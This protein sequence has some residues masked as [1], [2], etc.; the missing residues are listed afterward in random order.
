MKLRIA[1][2]ACAGAL[3]AILWTF[4]MSAGSMP[5][6]NASTVLYVT[7]PIALARHHA[8]SLYS[9][10]LANAA[11]YA[12]VGMVSEAFWWRYRRNQLA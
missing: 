6:G 1:L 11:S 4:Y 9:V 5:L 3:V 2:W 10:L 7:C 8:L 12:L